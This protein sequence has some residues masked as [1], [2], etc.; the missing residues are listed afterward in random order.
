MKTEELF[1]VLLK[2]FDKK[3]L[4]KIL[5]TQCV[6]NPDESYI[7]IND[8]KTKVS[9]SI[10]YEKQYD[11]SRVYADFI[12]IDNTIAWQ[13]KSCEHEIEEDKIRN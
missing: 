8:K 11:T 2:Q 10:F 4:E 1:E 12:K 13:L 5:I 9:M 3:Y 7:V 6:R